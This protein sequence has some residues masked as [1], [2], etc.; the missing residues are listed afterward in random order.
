MSENC[1]LTTLEIRETDVAVRV[2]RETPLF[3]DRYFGDLTPLP[4]YRNV[5]TENEQLLAI[6]DAFTIGKNLFAYRCYLSVQHDLVR[7]GKV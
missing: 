7:K 6:R 1:A 5:G 2:K 4:A 3:L